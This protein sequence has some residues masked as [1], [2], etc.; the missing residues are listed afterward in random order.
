MS[1]S[2]AF[3][4]IISAAIVLNTIVLS[5][6]KYPNDAKKM[7]FMD[8]L[9]FI[10]YCVFL[11][12]MLIKMLATGLRMY[13]R[14]PY[15]TFDFFVVI[16]STIDILTQQFADN[17]STGYEAIQA[18]RVFR[19]L[20]VFKLAKV[21]TEFNY[22]LITVF[23]TLKK[24]APFSVLVLIVAFSFT[25]LG[26]ELFSRKLSFDDDNRPIDNDYERGIVN[27]QGTV[28]DWN[29]NNF[30]DGFICVFIVIANDGWS[31][32]YYDHVRSMHWFL[33][34]IFFVLLILIGQFILFQLFL[35]ILLQ[36][37]EERSLIE[38]AT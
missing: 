27:M 5:M 35:A 2:N 30:R 37:F 26:L 25:I 9:N 12:E 29:F 15:N 6:D 32:I 18:L 11:F 28:P 17:K 10:F 24:V 13:F 14:D 4:Y 21:W 31:P 23:K 36:E 16:V 38:T 20:R 8:F 7:I 19:L 33:P 22:I 1:T 34:T 3:N